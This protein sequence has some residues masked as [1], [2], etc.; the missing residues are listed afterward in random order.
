MNSMECSL[1]EAG[2]H[3]RSQQIPHILLNPKGHNCVH[4]SL[5]LTP[6]LRQIKPAHMLTPCSFK[7]YFNIILPALIFQSVSSFQVSQI[8]FACMG[9]GYE[10]LGII[11]LQVYSYIYSLLGGVTT[12]V[13]PLSN[14]ALGPMMLPLLGTFLELLLWNSFH[15]CHYFFWMSSVS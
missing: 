12:G 5:P 9:Y 14:Y 6:S 7:V 13:L 15:C 3:P 1:W 10:V 11:L 4:M 2:S 8:K